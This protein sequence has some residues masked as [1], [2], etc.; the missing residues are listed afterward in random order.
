MQNKVGRENGAEAGW[1]GVCGRGWWVD[2]GA[3]KRTGTKKVVYAQA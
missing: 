1:K 2:T 3:Y